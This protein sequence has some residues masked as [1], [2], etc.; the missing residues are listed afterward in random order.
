MR[1][2][3]LTDPDDIKYAHQIASLIGIT[4]DEPITEG[5]Y[6]DML[7][8]E[9]KVCLESME[10]YYGDYPMVKSVI[11]LARA[12]TRRA[13]IAWQVQNGYLDDQ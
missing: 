4:L 13:Y 1:K 8:V 6:R 5:V 11:S 3:E 7:D 12:T 2:V 9:W 10:Q